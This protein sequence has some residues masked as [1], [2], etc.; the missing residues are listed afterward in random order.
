VKS[1]A[2]IHFLFFKGSL[3]ALYLEDNKVASAIR[4]GK[5][6]SGGSPSQTKVSFESNKNFANKC[7]T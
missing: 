1:L 2:D 7:A 4:E 6:K 5:I 3:L